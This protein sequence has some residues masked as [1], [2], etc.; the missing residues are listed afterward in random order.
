MATLQLDRVWVNHLPD[1][2]AV[3]AYSAV[4]RTRSYSQAGEV[5]TYAGGRQRSIT[6]AGTAGTFGF[7][8]RLLTSASIDTLVS[9]IGQTVQVRDARGQRFFGVFYA[10]EVTEQRDAPTLYD[11]ALTVNVVDQVEGV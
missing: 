6:S 10:V 2:A 8:L 1:G 9:W 7:T 5:R 11:V 3:A 4:E